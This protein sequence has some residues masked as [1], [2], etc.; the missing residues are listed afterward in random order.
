MN[1]FLSSTN[2]FLFSSLSFILF[3]LIILPWNLKKPPQHCTFL[4]ASWTQPN[5]HKPQSQ[6]HPK[7]MTPDQHKIECVQGNG[8]IVD[9]HLKYRL[10]LIWVSYLGCTFLGL[11]CGGVWVE[12]GWWRG[13]RNMNQIAKIGS[14]RK[15]T[16]GSWIMSILMET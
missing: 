12:V 9:L 5:Y 10:L 15:S 1:F 6:T 4:H 7:T 11:G 14:S 13:G 8:W 3:F 16:M 2:P